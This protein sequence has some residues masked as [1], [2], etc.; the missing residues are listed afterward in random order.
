MASEPKTRPT[1]ASVPDFIAAIEH[2]LRRADAEAACAL[3]ADVTGEPPVLWGTSIIGFGVYR[4]PTGDWPRIGFAS[5]KTETVFYIMSG[6]QE[7]ADLVE[8]LGGKARTG[9]S[10]LYIKRM[11]AVNRQALSALC[12]EAVR[13]MRERYPPEP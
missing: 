8:A 4:G 9:G 7:R 5:R 2:P 10:C 12:E 11:D 13:R 3:L 1:D 6:L